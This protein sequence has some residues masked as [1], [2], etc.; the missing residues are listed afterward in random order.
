M[1]GTR[2]VDE[3]LA[4]ELG[5]VS[6]LSVQPTAERNFRN[7]ESRCSA[8]SESALA[9]YRQAKRLWPVRPFPTCAGGLVRRQR[10]RGRRGAA[11]AGRPDLSAPLRHAAAGRD[12]RADGGD[13]RGSCPGRQRSLELAAPSRAAVAREAPNILEVMRVGARRRQP[14]P[15]PPSPGVVCSARRWAPRTSARM[16]ASTVVSSSAWSTVIS[17]VVSSTTARTCS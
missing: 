13:P 8:V 15:V 2:P 5:D 3:K 10:S 17:P 16:S 7:L 4:N 11:P 14:F 9:P 1:P 6:P 12:R